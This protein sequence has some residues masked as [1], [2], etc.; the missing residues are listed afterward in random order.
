MSSE[1]GNLRE[2]QK[3]LLTLQFI[4]RFLVVSIALWWWNRLSPSTHLN[5]R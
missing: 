5:E 1:K 2:K 4:L 3:Y